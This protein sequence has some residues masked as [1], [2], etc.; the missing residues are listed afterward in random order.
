MGVAV[1]ERGVPFAKAMADKA[2]T[3][4]NRA[5]RQ[6]AFRAIAASG[7]PEVAKWFFNDFKDPRLT[8]IERAVYRRRLPR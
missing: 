4:T 1:Q 2:I 5:M 7:D 8:P 6:G 3:S